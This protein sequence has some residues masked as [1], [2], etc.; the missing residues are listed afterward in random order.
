MRLFDKL[1]NAKS[2]APTPAKTD[3]VWEATQARLKA[4]TDQHE[5]EA[6]ERNKNR[7]AENI[8]ELY[9]SPTK[10]APPK[11]SDDPW[12]VRYPADIFHRGGSAQ[13]YP[14]TRVLLDRI[15]DKYTPEQKA[16]LAPGDNIFFASENSK[17]SE[18]NEAKARYWKQ[19]HENTGSSVRARLHRII[20]ANAIAQEECRETEVVPHEPDELIAAIALQRQAREN[21]ATNSRLRMPIL[22]SVCARIRDAARAQADEI[23]DQEEAQAAAFG[24][25]FFPSRLLCYLAWLGA[26]GAMLPAQKKHH[27]VMSVDHFQA[28]FKAK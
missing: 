21:I 17:L 10:P 7:T 4:K 27:G 5:A 24:I 16:Q 15:A 18:L 1:F 23:R 11:V 13:L 3:P 20:S 14:L 22:E 19:L 9:P 28:F 8:S 12:I 6:A 25:P 2:D 26:E